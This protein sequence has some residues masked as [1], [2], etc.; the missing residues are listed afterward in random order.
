M[1]KFPQII[2]WNQFLSDSKFITT[3]IHVDLLMTLEVSQG[4]SDA[5][6]LK[7]DINFL[8]DIRLIKTLSNEIE[9]FWVKDVNY[10]F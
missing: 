7:V 10:E 1:F 9:I 6:D 8:N 4:S 5:I 2:N 3:E